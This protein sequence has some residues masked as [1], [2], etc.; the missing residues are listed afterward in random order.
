MAFWQL[1]DKKDDFGDFGQGVF[2]RWVDS[3]G[4]SFGGWAPEQEIHYK[5]H[6]IVT[7]GHIV[8]QNKESVTVGLSY[9]EESKQWDGWVTIPKCS[10]VSFIYLKV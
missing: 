10:I 4:P 1:W 8:R 9:D 5:P 2:I 3:V 7:L 6:T